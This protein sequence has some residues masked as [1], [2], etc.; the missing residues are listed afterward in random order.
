MI[1]SIRSNENYS[2]EVHQYYDDDVER[3]FEIQPESNNK[4]S[5]LIKSF[6]HFIFEK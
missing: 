6:K 3:I 1:R 5:T 2:E 4:V